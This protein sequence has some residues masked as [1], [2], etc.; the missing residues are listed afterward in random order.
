MASGTRFASATQGVRSNAFAEAQARLAE[1]IAA[2]E[3]E[4]Q[5]LEERRRARRSL[6]APS[7]ARAEVQEL[8]RS[9]TTPVTPSS[10]GMH[11]R[12]L[13]HFD[14]VEGEGQGL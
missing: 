1:R 2:A 9:D 10:C 5:E 13:F 12:N 3:K 7:F 8:R 4:K 14:I 11:P 6:P